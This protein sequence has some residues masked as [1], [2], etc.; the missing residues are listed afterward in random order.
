MSSLATPE[1]TRRYAER[2]TACAPGHFRDLPLDGTALRLSSL[3]LGSYTGPATAAADS[4]YREAVR[5][6]VLRG[7][8]LIDCAINYRHMRSER[9]L[10]DGLRSLFEADEAKRDEVF[11]MTKAGYLPFDGN[12]PADPQE[13]FRRTY[14][15]PGIIGSGELVAHSHCIA[16]RFLEDQLGRSLRNFGLEAMDVLFLHNVEQQLDE[17]EPDPFLERV[18]AAFA[19]LEGLAGQG[20]IGMYGVATWN[21]FRVPPEAPGHLSLERLV[22]AAERAGGPNHRF[23]V[24]QLPFNLGMPESLST[25]TQVLQGGRVPL[26]EAA[27]RLGMMVVTS[28]PLLQTQLLPHVPRPSV[29]SCPA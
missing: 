17:V 14:V 6:A 10:G 21:G 28:V 22:R 4:Q 1:G 12:V 19:C 5:E 24:L 27:A 13:Y 8:N 11:V 20:R 18:E 25:P 23:R 16:P 29:G 2:M 7:C 9:A 15:E 3:G 26:F